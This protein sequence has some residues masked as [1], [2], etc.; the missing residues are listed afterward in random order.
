MSPRAALRHSPWLIWAIGAGV[1]FF[2]FIHRASLG[3][4]G[5]GAVDRLG[6]SSTQL[7]SFIMVQLGLYA[8]MQVPA[9]M[10]IDRW[11]ARRVLL[12]AT[13]AMGTA[14]TMFAFAQSYPLALL[15]RGLLGIGDAAVFIAVLRLAATYFPR[16]QYAYLTTLTGLAGMLGNLAATVPLVL[17]LQNWGWTTT[18]L[19]SGAVSLAYALLL[20]RPAVR[21]GAEPAAHRGL[22]PPPPPTGLAEV[23]AV[24]GRSEVRLGFWTHFATLHPALVLSL[25]WAFPYLTEGLGYTS[26]AAASML[27][28]YI[29]ANLVAS[30]V[31]GPLAGR[32]PAWRTPMALGIA[33]ACTVSLAGLVLWPGGIPP[34]WF[35]TAVFIVVAIGAP[36]SQI[37][38]H[39]ARDYNPA[40]SMST[41]TGVVNA[42]GFIGAMIASV[43]IGVV[44]DARA[45]ESPGLLDYRWALSTLVVTS[46]V[47]TLTMFVAL[48]GVRQKAL[49]RRAGGQ[50]VVVQLTQR[51]WDRLY[52]RLVRQRGR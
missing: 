8:V 22:T 16:R 40:G 44:L 3:V 47:S 50:S 14:Q 15:A 20:L 42:G 9:G 49:K 41:A 25:L 12:A 48:L 1:Y 43:A 23:R 18:F 6:I 2:G 7:G 28:V 11:G 52:D 24:W 19:T 45:G 13:L 33:A 5:P 31:V 21:R 27:S 17:A 10:A 39:L 46:A 29:G 30:F 37:G 51:P 38:F 4:A 26:A 36:T 35:V 32:K 34:L